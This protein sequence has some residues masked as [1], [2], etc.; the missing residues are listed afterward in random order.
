MKETGSHLTAHTTIQ[1]SRTA[2]TVLDRK[3]AVS[4]GIYHLFSAFSVSA[5]NNGL[6][7]EFLASSLRIQKFR[8]WRLDLGTEPTPGNRLLSASFEQRPDLLRVQS[9]RFELSAPFSGSVAESLDTNAA[10]QTTLDRRFDEVR[11][12]ESERDGHIDLTYAA[13]LA[14]GDLLDVSGRA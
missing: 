8:S 10:G 13:F 5:Y 6:T 3:E 4:A 14:C 12:E 1:S 11:G 7:G 9:Q 2:E